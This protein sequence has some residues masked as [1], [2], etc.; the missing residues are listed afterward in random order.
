MD[1][2]DFNRH[3]RFLARL[4]SRDG[5]ADR[6]VADSARQHEDARDEQYLGSLSGQPPEWLL[7]DASRAHLTTYRDA[8][9]VAFL[10]GGGA[11]GT[12]CACDG[13]GD[14]VT[15]PAAINGNNM[16]SEAVVAGTAP[17]TVMRGTIPTLETL[18]PRQRTRRVLPLA[19]VSFIRTV[20]YPSP[21]EV[22]LC[23]YRVPHRQVSP[24]GTHVR[25]A[26]MVE[27]GTSGH[28]RHGHV[29]AGRRPAGVTF[30]RYVLQEQLPMLGVCES[31]CTPAPPLPDDVDSALL[32]RGSR[33]CRLRLHDFRRS[34]CHGRYWRAPSPL[35]SQTSTYEQ[36]LANADAS[37]QIVRR[38]EPLS[39]TFRLPSP[40][41][42]S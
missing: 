5:Q 3:A 31:A 27:R 12:T 10:F 33:S 26:K 39:V 8:G 21:A 1:A 16:A 40:F 9:V 35:I 37:G 29:A 36:L 28:G 6:H 15:N 7:D 42:R 13:V 41:S 18:V 24:C 23:A 11:G 30:E 34:R 22:L 17:S 4:L 14:G 2:A 20:R 32:R 25:Q 38:L 19:S